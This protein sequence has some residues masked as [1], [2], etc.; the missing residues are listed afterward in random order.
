MLTRKA[1]EDQADTNGA[2]I[3]QRRMR[4]NDLDTHAAKRPAFVKRE[5]SN[6]NQKATSR[7]FYSATAKYPRRLRSP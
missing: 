3:G 2:V 1:R 6:I 7:L 5:P 4:K